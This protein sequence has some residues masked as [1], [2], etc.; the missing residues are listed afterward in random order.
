MITKGKSKNMKGLVLEEYNQAALILIGLLPLNQ[1]RAFLFM[2]EFTEICEFSTYI[3]DIYS[4]FMRISEGG[5]SI[6]EGKV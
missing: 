6:H 2:N 3:M 4:F 1:Y 5:I